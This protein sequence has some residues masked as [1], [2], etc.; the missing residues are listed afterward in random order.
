MFKEFL[1][2]M[3]QIHRLYNML[4]KNIFHMDKHMVHK[5]FLFIHNKRN[6]HMIRPQLQKHIRL[7]EMD[8]PYNHD[9]FLHQNLHNIQLNKY[10]LV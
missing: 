7:K 5:F 8:I 10:N 2:M 3:V 1:F 9:S 6:L 4:Q